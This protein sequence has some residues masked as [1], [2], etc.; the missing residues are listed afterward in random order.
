MIPHKLALLSAEILRI[1]CSEHWDKE[2]YGCQ[3]CIFKKGSTLRSC[4]LQFFMGFYGKEIQDVAD[5]EVRAVCERLSNED[6]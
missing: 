5:S 6:S 1:Y 3:K 4:R 2:K